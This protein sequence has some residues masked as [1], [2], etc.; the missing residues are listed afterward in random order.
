MRGTGYVHALHCGVMRLSKSWRYTRVASLLAIVILLCVG[1]FL[2]FLPAG[3]EVPAALTRVH[4]SHVNQ[5]TNRDWHPLNGSY[6]AVPLEEEEV[7]K[8]PVDADLL[9]TLL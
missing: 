2:S 8:H 4:S 9:S 3:I 5:A 1:A 6:L 7:D